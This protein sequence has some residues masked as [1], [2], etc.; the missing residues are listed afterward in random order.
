[1]SEQVNAGKK[2]VQMWIWI[3]LAATAVLYLVISSIRG[4]EVPYV[5]AAAIASAGSRHVRVAGKVAAGGIESDGPGDVSIRFSLIDEHGDTV[6]VEYTGVRPDA[7]REGAQAV[8]EGRFDAG[9]GS[10]NAVLLQAKCP[11]K[12]EVGVS[13]GSGPA[14]S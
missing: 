1:M 4:T 7:F 10:F 14:K 2:P 11:S 9:R 12:Y 3:F 5:D 8:V 13:G 6:L